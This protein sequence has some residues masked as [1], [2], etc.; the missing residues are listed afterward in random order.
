MEEEVD[1]VRDAVGTVTV[2]VPVA[3]FLPTESDDDNVKV[4]VPVLLKERDMVVDGVSW[5]LVS[6]SVAIAL[7]V[8]DSEPA[9]TLD[10]GLNVD[11]V[12][13]VGTVSVGEPID[14]VVDSLG[15]I[16][17]EVVVLVEGL[18]LCVML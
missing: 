2:S 9:V 14:D 7:N 18:Q 13:I 16:D 11:D 17:N 12:E 1:V 5:E 6:E 4:A 15:V 8:G 3:V 10:E